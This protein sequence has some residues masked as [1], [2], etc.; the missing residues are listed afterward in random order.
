MRLSVSKELVTVAPV[1]SKKLVSL[2]PSIPRI[3]DLAR[4]LFR[5][6]RLSPICFIGAEPGEAQAEPRPQDH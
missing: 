4:D 2:P 5:D 3:P 6:L 1:H